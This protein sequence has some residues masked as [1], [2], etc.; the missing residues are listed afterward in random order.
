MA[1][2]R[3]RFSHQFSQSP[4]WLVSIMPCSCRKKNE[5]H[6]ITFSLN[7]SYFCP[8]PVLMLVSYTELRVC[9]CRLCLVAPSDR[10]SLLTRSQ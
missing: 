9:V 5:Q 4:F 1:Q 6:A 2:K 3:T 8:E 10:Q 7:F